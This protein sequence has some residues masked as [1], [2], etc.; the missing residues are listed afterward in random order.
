[1][2][3]ISVFA[4]L[5]FTSIFAF[6]TFAAELPQRARGHDG[7][8]HGGSAQF[9]KSGRDTIFLIGP[10][11][12]GAQVNGQFQNEQGTPA[13]NNWTHWD[14]TQIT[15]THWHVSDYAASNLNATPGN[16]AA[17][18]G[19]AAY[20]SCD[21]DDPVGGYGNSWH[22]IL[23][24][25]YVVADASMGCTMTV[26]GIFNSN[27][28]PGYDYT[29]FR[30]DTADAPVDQSINDG[31]HSAEPFNY[32]H[33]YGPADYVGQNNNE[34]CF[35]IVVTS[36]SGWSD[37]DCSYWGDGACQV[38]D[39]TVQCTNGNYYYFTD[40]QA[41]SLNPFIPTFPPGVGDFAEIWTHLEDVD[42]C[43]S[44]Y[45][46]QV[47]FI[48][49]GTQVE[50][51]GPSYCLNWCYGPGGYI[52]NTTGGASVDGHLWNVVESP[53]VTWP[54]AEFL[55][56][57]VEFDIYRHEDLSA[58]A[59]GIFYNWGVR[60]TADEAAYPIASRSWMDRTFVY[61]GGPDY[62]RAGDVVSDLMEPGV[63]HAQVQ[64]SCFELG[65][66]WGWDGDDGYP[67]PY[68]DNVSFKAFQAEGPGMYTREIDIAQDN[69]TEIGEEV[70]FSDLAVNNVRFDGAMNKAVGGEEHNI[71]R[72]SILCDVASV[73]VG[74]ELTSNR[75]V[76]TMQR[77][78]VFDSVRDPDWGV[79]GATPGIE[80]NYQTH[81]CYDLPD[82]GFL[83]PG[84]VLHY[85][86]EA[87]DEVGH[88]D[89]QTSTLPV[90][91]S[92]F[93]DFST[94]TAYHTGF[95]VHALPSIDAD[96]S[97]PGILLWN[98]FGNRGG[99]NE[100]YSALAGLDLVKGVDYDVYYTN[101]PSSG[102][103]CGLGGR[104]VYEQ[105][106]N[107]TDLLYTCGNLGVNTIS[108]GDFNNDPGRDI[109]LLNDWFA[110]GEG[111]DAFFTGDELVTDLSQAGA[112]TSG[113]VNDMMNVQLHTNNIRPLINNQTTPLILPVEQNSVFYTTTAWIAYGGCM[114]INTFDAFEAGDGAEN[115][116]RFTNPSGEPDYIY[117]AATLNMPDDDRIITMPYDFMFIYTDPN[118]PISPG[119]AARTN[120]LRE[121]LAFFQVPY[122]GWPISDVLPDAARFTVRNHPNP[123]NPAT[124]I[125]FNMPR[126][127]QLTL[128][129]YNVRG[130]LVKTLIDE[131]RAAGSG[132]VMWD[133]TNAQGSNVSSGVYFYEARTGGEIKVNKIALVK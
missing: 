91:I 119:V 9:T 47:A 103:G 101:G 94:P 20:A 115:L 6:N 132:H 131:T 109:Q 97:Q 31:I 33:A 78:P 121:I 1:M 124:R 104:A 12:S 10:W 44:N 21:P 89:P 120:M 68:F 46:A 18:C 72:D 102:V 19:D 64:F 25:N 43:I 125:E 83:F 95:Q 37:E 51:V 59:P 93:G 11:G 110:F 58:D 96:G 2:K 88:T 27:T 114:G 60:S 111:R 24:F 75:L 57:E 80:Q 4:C 35:Q 113:F 39:I 100:W 116:A 17:Y 61:Y 90:D 30:F 29:T 50:G 42:P 13:W 53:V 122:I 73:R 70:D 62:V 32:S 105:I 86:F 22:D 69:F 123:F 112:L 45:S 14:V 16:L 49:D 15:E 8:Y 85:Y 92:G 118:H 126:D 63:T 48:D 26:S 54:G 82:S 52:V 74:G 130:E 55:G 76:Y 107:Y 81:Y 77:N 129:I 36:D 84:D 41:E 66:V 23:E 133:G 128:K 79:S 106:K 65:Y 98:D 71:P 108:N 127:G 5:A 117:S 34:V 3:R 67:A 28:E 99:E 87:T 38:D 40:F 56:A 7:V